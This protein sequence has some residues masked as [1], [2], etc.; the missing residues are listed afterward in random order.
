M[1]IPSRKIW[2]TLLA[3]CFVAPFA[4][5]QSALTPEVPNTFITEHDNHGAN[6]TSNAKQLDEALATVLESYLEA[7]QTSLAEKGYRSSYK[8]GNLDPRLSERSCLTPIA[9]SFTR[10]P[11]SHSRTTVLAECKQP[12]SWKLFVNVD[13]TV[14]APR[15]VAATGIARGQ[16]IETAHLLMRE[17]QINK[18]QQAGF[19]DPK[20]IVGMLAKRTIRPDRVITPDIL[21]PPMLVERGDEVIITAK[22]SKLKIKMKGTALTK[23]RKGQQISVRNQQS[24]RV[25][26]AFVEDRGQVSVKL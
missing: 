8:I 21:T 26:S 10:S 2:I 20:H 24:N 13:F 3:W 9:L 12:A 22:N 17:V 23:G 19:G 7:E 6:H 15:F 5:A 25:I 4:L 11:L 16:R 1:K 14:M 18:H